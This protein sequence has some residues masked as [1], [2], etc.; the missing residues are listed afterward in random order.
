MS[1]REDIFSDLAR[2]TTR[3]TP[4]SILVKWVFSPAFKTM[5]LARLGAHLL[6]RGKIGRVLSRLVWR[7]NVASSACYISNEAHIGRGLLL[8]HP[9]GIVIGDGVRIGMDVT[10]YQNVT[11]GRANADESSY[12][13]IGDGVIIYAGA[14][15][16]GAV[17]IGEGSVVAANSVVNRDVPPA[18]LVGGVPAKTLLSR[19]GS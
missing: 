1:F 17:R 5:V 3:R 11:L 2:V 10:I 7:W 19:R 9:T 14:V 16:A 6:T 4:Q 12:P 8:P 13:H 18:T 15:I